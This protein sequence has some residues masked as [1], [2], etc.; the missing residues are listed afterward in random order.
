MGPKWH[1]VT[2]IGNTGNSPGGVWEGSPPKFLSPGIPTVFLWAFQKLGFRR[3]I[4]TK[5]IW[6][7]M[8]SRRISHSLSL[9]PSFFLSF[10][11]SL[12]L[13][14][15]LFCFLFSLF[16]LSSLSLSLSRFLSKAESIDGVTVWLN[17]V[18]R[19]CDTEKTIMQTNY[20]HVSWIKWLMAVPVRIKMEFIQN[21]DPR[22]GNL[23]LAST[24]TCMF[25]RPNPSSFQCAFPMCPTS[26]DF[27]RCSL[28]T[29]ITLT[30]HLHMTHFR[31]ANVMA[32]AVRKT[33]SPNH[34][35]R[36]L[37]SVFTFGSIFVNLQAHSIHYIQGSRLEMEVSWSRG[38]INF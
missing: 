29:V 6:E 17:N 25:P 35:L 3:S 28:I 34:P 2:R 14:L 33:L 18:Q 26:P 12:S 13:S 24:N 7:C 15:S 37:L 38:A 9:S 31:A 22:C 19:P 20:P 21:H 30:D 5:N 8:G 1:V 36:R 27:A 4:L 11:L 23:I 10:F 16:S 32:T